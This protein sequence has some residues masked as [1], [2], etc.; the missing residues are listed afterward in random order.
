MRQYL[1]EGLRTEH[2]ANVAA[3]SSVS[4]LL[5]AK[6]REEVLEARA[7]L[8]DAQHDLHVPLPCMDGIIPRD[9][10]ALGIEEGEVRDIALLSRVG[11][12]VCFTVREIVM[13]EDGRPL[14]V[15]SRRRAQHLCKTEYLSRLRSGDIVTAKVTRLEGFGAFCDIGCGVAALLPIACMS[16]SRITHPRDRVKVGD[17][18]R[19]VV[20]SPEEGRICLSL[21]ELLGTWE[22]NAALFTAGE[23]VLGTVR[24]VE[25]YGA[26]VE[27]MPNLAGLAEPFDGARVGQTA[28]VFI[29]SILPAKM[30][31]KLVMIDT[32]DDVAAPMPL[33]YFYD[34][35][36]VERWSY[37][38]FGHPRF[39][40]TTF[41]A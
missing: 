41:G 32:H 23:T 34:G 29:K 28:S 17:V 13:R 1:P 15:L 4:G 22:E 21:R 27:L 5:A 18:L 30:K 40:Q 26:F 12:P 2:E 14:A 20:T 8:C 9:E 37:A 10:G 6:E 36:R 38:P 11:K 31:I 33:R 25:P 39:A 35:E 3:I 24:S 7:V 16:V 19:C